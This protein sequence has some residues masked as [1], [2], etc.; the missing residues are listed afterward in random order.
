MQASKGGFYRLIIALLAMFMIAAA[1]G[2]SDDDSS[3]GGDAVQASSSDDAADSAEEE[4][5]EEDEGGGLSQDAVEKAIS[6]DDEEEEVDADA[7][8]FDRS[9]LDG[10]WEEAAYNRQLMI[11][12][13]TE[14]M[15]AGEWGVG[16]DNVL[17][18]PTGYE[19]DL[20]GCPGDW[21]NTHGVSDS[22]LRLG[23]TLVQSGNL[24]AYGNITHG[25]INYFDW[26]NENDGGIGGRA[27][28][29][30]V[31]DDGYVAAQTIEYVDE[32]IESENVF[33]IQNGGSPN[34][35]AVYDK[36]NEECIPHPFYI[37]GHPAWGDPVNHPWTTGMQM[38]YATEAMLW[39]TWI[40]SNLG[41]QLPVKVAG[42][43]MDN[44]FGL[45]YEIGFENYAEANPDV[46]SEYLP[47]RHDP[48]APTLT[49]EVTTIAAF[50]PDVFISMTAGNPCLLAIQEVEAAGLL[51]TMSAAFTPSV[52]KGI[53]AYMAPAGMGADKWWVVGGGLKDTSDPKYIDEPFISFLNDNL[54]AA[55]LDPAISLLGTGY[56]FG[57]PYV[58]AL[59]VAN[60]LPGGLT[61]T[62]FMLAQRNFRIYHPQTMAGITNEMIGATDAYFVEGSDFSQFDAVAQTW[63]QVGDIVD[64]NGGT[65]NCAWDKS[66]GGCR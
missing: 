3:S 13:I 24:A 1:C 48:A 33:A 37:S 26:V 54:T 55:G 65:A 46:V 20:N 42:L 52:C 53:A 66:N 40:K 59:R 15:N 17:R 4:A 49:N 18:G 36:I 25:M 14:K 44:D 45:A 2:G 43:V 19:I 31:F 5:A 16:D 35:L 50:D 39:G 11:D 29:M 12:E 58:E 62:N 9:T 27:I 47:V 60:E 41:D 6:G 23:H 8:T 10:I 30:I 7:P 57:Y 38:S 32:L 61:R 64:A 22:E 56:M 28:N 63:N 21:S 51:E 34:G